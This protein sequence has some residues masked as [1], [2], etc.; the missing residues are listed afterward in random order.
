MNGVL[1][2]IRLML[3]SF[4]YGT[5]KNWA[6]LFFCFLLGEETSPIKCVR[7]LPWCPGVGGDYRTRFALV[8]KVHWAGEKGLLRGSMAYRCMGDV[9]MA[10][11]RYRV[12][13]TR[14]DGLG[15]RMLKILQLQA[16]RSSEL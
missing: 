10:E 4:F 1:A 5:R 11:N 3:P 12:R 6:F 16:R 15:A 13:R 14:W 2:F 8:V 9:Y 7:S